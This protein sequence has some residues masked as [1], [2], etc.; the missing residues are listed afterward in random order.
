MKK[1][2][3]RAAFLALA[4]IALSAATASAQSYPDAP[5]TLVVPSSAGG[6]SDTVGRLVANAVAPF[7]G[8]QVVVE[9]RDGA[10]ATI[11]ADIVAKSKPDGYTWLIIDNAHAANV[12]LRS[13]LSYDILKDFVPVTQTNSAPHVLVVHPSVEANSV[14]DLVALAKA[15]PGE[16]NYASAG[17]GTVTF[18]AAE[19]FKDQAGVDLIEIPY[20]G[21][22]NS[23]RAIVAGETQV[24]FSP[25]LVALPY[26][27]DGRLRALA[28][29]SKTRV[30]LLPDVPT[31][32]ESGYPDYEF[33]LW[34][35]FLVPANTP[36][37][38]VKKIHDSIVAA[39]ETDEMRKK[40][41]DMGAV[42]VG[43]E[44]EEFGAFIK[45]QVDSLSELIHKLGLQPQ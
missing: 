11:G 18:L 15:K 27:A 39:I 28:V 1:T 25:L 6:A 17:Q 24:Y 44:S 35:G 4:G 40:L 22:G 38:V 36:P 14:A 20:K 45:A 9:N 7:L 43:S 30:D 23:L 42:V 10:S 26:I 3:F 37:E 12:S 19:I 16:I 5:I 34:N 29:T 8:Q 13:N 31:I 33:N 41:A 32:A 21:G 2:G